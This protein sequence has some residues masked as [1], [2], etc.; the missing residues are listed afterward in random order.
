MFNYQYTVIQITME[1]GV[2]STVALRT[3]IHV[4]N[5]RV[6]KYAQMVSTNIHSSTTRIKICV[7]NCLYRTTSHVKNAQHRL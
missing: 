3:S 7:H 4:T 5:R 1:A 2:I 6:Q